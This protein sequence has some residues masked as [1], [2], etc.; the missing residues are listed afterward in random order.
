MEVH[1]LKTQH[2]HQT[3]ASAATVATLKERVRD[4]PIV[5]RP[6]TVLLAATR[7]TSLQDNALANRTAVMAKFMTAPPP[8]RPHA[9]LVRPTRT[10]PPPS[11]G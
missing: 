7:T 10:K 2:A 5:I 8:R 4:A 6:G 11:I 9:R 3:S 1:A